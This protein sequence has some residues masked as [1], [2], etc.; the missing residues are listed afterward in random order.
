MISAFTGEG[1]EQVTQFLTGVLNGTARRRTALVELPVL[2]NIPNCRQWAA[3]VG[4]RADYH[5]PAPPIWTRRLDSVFLH[6][7][8]GPVIF[9][10][11][12]VAVFQTIFAGARPI[13]DAMQNAYRDLRP[14][15]RAG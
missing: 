12:V 5:A 10:M 11:V 13:M 15:D 4:R 3:R 8:L 6:P 1:V 9:A 2:N 7:V 14:V